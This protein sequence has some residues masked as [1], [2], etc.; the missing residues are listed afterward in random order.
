MDLYK[1]AALVTVLTFLYMLKDSIRKYSGSIITMV[2]RKSK[3]IKKSL[4]YNKRV[5]SNNIN[6]SDYSKIK[7]KVEN[8][9]ANNIE[10][11]AYHTYRKKNPLVK[12]TLPD[13]F[14]ENSMKNLLAKH[15]LKV[16]TFDFNKYIKK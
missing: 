10:R 12:L 16:P 13:D 5:R 11:D 7:E 6:S 15:T 2:K 4:E 3:K 14:L 9:I 8:G 1:L